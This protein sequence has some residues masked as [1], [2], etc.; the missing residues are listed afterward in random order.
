[1]RHNNNLQTD[2]FLDWKIVKINHTSNHYQIKEW[3]KKYAEGQW[4][5]Q[6]T[7]Y[8]FENERDATIFKLR[9]S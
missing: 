2:V 5:Q 7:N 1:M 9:W 6:D 3:L 8:L 4:Q